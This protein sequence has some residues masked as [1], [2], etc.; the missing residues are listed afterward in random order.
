LYIVRAHLETRP[1]DSF[2]FLTYWSS[3]HSWL[4]RS[5]VSTGNL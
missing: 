4:E 1:I 3:R 2:R 5:R